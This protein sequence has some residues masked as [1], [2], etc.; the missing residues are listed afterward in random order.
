M[1]PLFLENPKTTVLGLGAGAALVAG[2]N[3]DTSD[4]GFWV[5]LVAA[6]VTAVA[7]IFSKDA[8]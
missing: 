5:R 4:P 7:G 8:K 6:L 3:F 2:S 1:R